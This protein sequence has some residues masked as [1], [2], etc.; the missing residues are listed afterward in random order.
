MR[1][2]EGRNNSKTDWERVDKLSDRQIA[3]TITNDTD[4]F[5]PGADWIKKASMPKPA[6]SKERLTV[7]FDA[8]MVDW[9]KRQGRGY[10]TRMNAI[11]RAYFEHVRK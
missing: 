8:D 7:R 2:G 11:L 6:H 5:D 1:L 3:R 10:Q 9:F 4:T